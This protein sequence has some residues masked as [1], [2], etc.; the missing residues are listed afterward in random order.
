MGTLEV[1]FVCADFNAAGSV[2]AMGELDV[3]EDLVRSLSPLNSR[4]HTA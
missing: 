4:R 3:E 2:K 1:N